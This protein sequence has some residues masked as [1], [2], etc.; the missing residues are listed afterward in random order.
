MS[1]A[2]TPPA[3]GAAPSPPA[4]AQTPGFG[5]LDP[6][7]GP[8][9][10]TQAVREMF[11][12]IASR[13]DLVNRLMTFGLDIT[14]RRRTVRALG[15]AAGCCVLDVAC[16][17]G[18]LSREL[19]RQQLRPIGADLSAGMLRAGLATVPVIQA[20]ASDLPVP[21][22]AVDGVACAF[23]MRNFSNLPAVLAEMGRVL[24]PGGR[25]ALLD[26]APTTG[27]VHMGHRLWF[28]RAVPIIGA[29]FSDPAA[30]R[31]LPRSVAYLPPTPE[32]LSWVRRAGFSGVNR[33]LL[34]GGIVQLITG[35]RTPAP[36]TSLVTRP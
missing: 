19:A 26:V 28:E 32:L 11:D 25:L 14:W 10:K 1:P 22:A 3:S 16:G 27:V 18:D 7:P 24:R 35:T 29:I 21:D 15:L 20:D 34:G 5:R 6:L 31:Y 17:T 13:Y 2:P 36:T 30:Y 23:G 12:T 8:D 9:Q 33:R 4:A